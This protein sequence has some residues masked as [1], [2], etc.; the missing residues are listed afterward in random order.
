MVKQ[1]WAL[2]VIVPDRDGDG[3]PDTWETEWGTDP[4]TPDADGDPDEDGFTNAEE[5]QNESDPLASDV[6]P[7]TDA[8]TTPG[9]DDRT[10]RGCGCTTHHPSSVPLGAMVLLWLLWLLLGARRRRSPFVLWSSQAWERSVCQ[11][12]TR[13]HLRNGTSDRGGG[14]EW[15]PRRFPR[16]RGAGPRAT[17]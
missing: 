16:P 15:E 17:S 4:D 10:H 14:H 6:T 11:P 3:L 2:F 13:S 7:Q 8:G 5:Y 12:V 1:S 9:P